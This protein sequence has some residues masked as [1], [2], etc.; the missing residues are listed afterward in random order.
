MP[1]SRFNSIITK[2]LAQQ[3]ITI[4]GSGLVKAKMAKAIAANGNNA[5]IFKNMSSEAISA[6]L[7]SY[8]QRP[9]HQQL[10]GAGARRQVNER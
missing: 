6:T 7:P 1:P 2:R 5:E 4:K 10:R 3:G 9:S 8:N